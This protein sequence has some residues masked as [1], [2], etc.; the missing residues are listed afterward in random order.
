MLLFLCGTRAPA[1]HAVAG[2][3]LRVPG[4]AVV[5]QCAG[6]RNPDCACAVHVNR[7]YP[8]LG[9]KFSPITL[10]ATTPLPLLLTAIDEVGFARIYAGF[11]YHHSV[12]QG[13]VL[14]HKVAQNVV[15]NYF[16]PVR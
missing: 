3:E 2:A 9:N 15:L 14:G 16:R 7:A 8:A 5:R 11:H 10:N 6:P 4:E 12:V 1:S 13:L